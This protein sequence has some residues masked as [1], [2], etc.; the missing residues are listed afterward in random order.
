MLCACRMTVPSV[1]CLS[2]G[3]IALQEPSWNGRPLKYVIMLQAVSGNGFLSYSVSPDR[4][5][6]T[7]TGLTSQVV[8]DV[9]IIAE[10]VIGRSEELLLSRCDLTFTPTPT[11]A[12]LTDQQSSPDLPKAT[13]SQTLLSTQMHRTMQGH[14]ATQTLETRAPVT[15]DAAT[16]DANSKTSSQQG[17][18]CS[19][20]L[21]E[22]NYIESP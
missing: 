6:W 20:L 12:Y 3:V 8:Y 15:H 10:N 18:L 9:R 2:F 5:S 16:N 1:W 17:Q 19:T 14:W 7:I 4:S 13:A 21:P 11:T 22:H